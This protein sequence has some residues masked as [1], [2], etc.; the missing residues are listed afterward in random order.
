[1]VKSQANSSLLGVQSSLLDDCSS[2]EIVW[3]WQSTVSE[4]CSKFTSS[5]SPRSEMIFLYTQSYYNL[6]PARQR[7][8][9]PSRRPRPPASRWS[10][11]TTPT[12]PLLLPHLLLAALVKIIS[13][14]SSESNLCSLAADSGLPSLGLLSLFKV[15][16]CSVAPLS[17]CLLSPASHGLTQRTLILPAGGPTPP[18]SPHSIL[19]FLSGAEI[20]CDLSPD[21]PFAPPRLLLLGI[22]WPKNLSHAGTHEHTNNVYSASTKILDILLFRCKRRRLSWGVIFFL[23]W[24]FLLMFQ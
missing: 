7:L 17:R 19:R 3:A 23:Y 24:T 21:Q 4:A 10:R 9:L 15:V 22:M 2:G 8:A 18:H 12:P 11:G 6:A 5:W 14:S 16:I 1:M 20:D 13:E